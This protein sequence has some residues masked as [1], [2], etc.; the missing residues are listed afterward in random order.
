MHVC[1]CVCVNAQAYLAKRGAETMT[2][3][4]ADFGQAERSEGASDLVDVELAVAISVKLPEDL[5]HVMLLVASDRG[6]PR[7]LVEL[8]AALDRQLNLAA[9]LGLEAGVQFV[10]AHVTVTWALKRGG[11]T[12]QAMWWYERNRER[13]EAVG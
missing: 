8:P 6:I 4:D 13:R 10:H 5:L 11:A 7:L 9:R 1:V 12:D 2:A 3:C